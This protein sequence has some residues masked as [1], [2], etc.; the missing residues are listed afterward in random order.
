MPASL[1]LQA[2]DFVR[3]RD[4]HEDPTRAGKDAL[5]MGVDGNGAALYFGL[6][7]SGRDQHVYCAGPEQWSL[8]E[9]DLRS[10]DRSNYAPAQEAT[11]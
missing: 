4:D 10:I 2:Q 9:L 3:V 11:R 1:C 7:R 6:D 5:V 8:D